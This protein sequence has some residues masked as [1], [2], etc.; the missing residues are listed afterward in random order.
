MLKQWKWNL[1]ILSENYDEKLISWF[2]SFLS[3]PLH[4][5]TVA[6]GRTIYNHSSHY[7]AHNSL[8]PQQP[9]HTTQLLT[10]TAHNNLQPHPPHK[11]THNNLQLQ[12]R[13]HNITVYNHSATVHTTTHNNL[14]PQQRL[15]TTQLL[16]V[17]PQPLH[18]TIPN[19]L[20]NH[21]HYT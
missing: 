8:Q 15:H 10:T 4:S 7:T 3:N 14:Q 1:K 20:Y 2:S 21:I 9:L 12:Q 18:T 16:T 5:L 11:T 13:L 6:K 17:Q 19:N